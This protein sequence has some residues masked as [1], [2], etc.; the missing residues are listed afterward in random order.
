MGDGVCSDVDVSRCRE[1]A[2]LLRG[3]RA[4]RGIALYFEAGP[5]SKAL[6]T[7][8]PWIGVKRAQQQVK[9]CMEFLA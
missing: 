2:D 5:G 8:P 9:L 1:A 3:E 7:L 6:Q 4:I